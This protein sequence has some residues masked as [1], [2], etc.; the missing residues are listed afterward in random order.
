[1]LRT[2]FHSWMLED[3]VSGYVLDSIGELTDIVNDIAP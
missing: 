1:M 2:S 3:Y